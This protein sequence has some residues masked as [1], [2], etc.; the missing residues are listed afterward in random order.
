MRLF[1]RCYKRLYRIN[2]GKRVQKQDRIQFI[3]HF[4]LIIKIEI[5]VGAC[6]PFLSLDST[7]ISIDSLTYATTNNIYEEITNL[8]GVV[9]GSD[10]KRLERENV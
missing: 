1:V 4:T 9:F 6:T 2:Q 10:Q 7:D 3:Y 8:I 5:L